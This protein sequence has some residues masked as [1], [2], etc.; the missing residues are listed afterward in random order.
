MR[1]TTRPAARRGARSAAAVLSLAA[2][3]LMAPAAPAHAATVSKGTFQAEWVS[4]TATRTAGCTQA[5]YGLDA[6][7]RAVDYYASTTNTCTGGT[8]YTR[9]SATPTTFEMS[10]HGARVVAAVAVTDMSG[11][12]T[13]EVVHVDNTWTPTSKVPRTYTD[14]VIIHMP[15]VY[16]LSERGWSSVVSASTTGSLPMDEATMTTG[17]FRSMSVVHG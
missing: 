4:G 16:R 14:P 3:A 9:G 1:A 15:G 13:G 6:R 17:G 11:R 8:V 12:P 10:R 7:E 2:G 5:W